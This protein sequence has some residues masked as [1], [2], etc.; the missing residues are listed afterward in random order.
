VAAGV[1]NHVAALPDQLLAQFPDTRLKKAPWTFQGHEGRQGAR[2]HARYGP[3]ARLRQRRG[4]TRRLSAHSAEGGK[5][6]N[7]DSRRARSSETGRDTR[8]RLPRL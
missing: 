2:Q 8:C 4:V 1:D 5:A 3:F 7:G 6:R